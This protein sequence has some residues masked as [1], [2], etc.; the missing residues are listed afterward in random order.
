MAQS[1][2]L[3]A[4]KKELGEFYKKIGA[5]Y[6]VRK[7]LLYGSYAKGCACAD[8]DIDV[9]VVVDL[10]DDIDK[11]AV[12]ADLLHLARSINVDIEPLCVLLNEYNNHEPASILSEIIRTSIEV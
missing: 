9:A 11:V 3:S 12:T 8:S 10:P 1:K 7:M 4:V 6:P 5:L 2:D